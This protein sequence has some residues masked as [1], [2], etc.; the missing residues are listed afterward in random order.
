MQVRTYIGVFS[1]AVLSN[2]L[3]GASAAPA[4]SPLDASTIM[5]RIEQRNPSLQTYQARV[6][7]HAHLLTFPW[8]SPD[9]EGTSYFKRPDYYEVVFDRVPAYAHGIDK[10]FGDISDP[11]AWQRD[12]NITFAGMKNV[13]G[14]PF[15]A[16][17][18]TKKIYSDQIKDT[19]AYIDPQTYQVVRMDYHYRDG[20]T[21]TM[22]QT[23][24]QEGPF[25]VIATQHAEIA[26]RVHAIADA[27]FGTYQ[28]NVAVNDSVFT[29]K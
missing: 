26:H 10:L 22:T 4:E 28:T 11:P 12:S 23:F 24:K 15:L 6:H 29:K 13:N 9:L 25:N 18:M 7:V 1:L 2:L 20:G 14:H 21:I 19:V 16:L 3:I 8:L 5:Q 27:V 17:E